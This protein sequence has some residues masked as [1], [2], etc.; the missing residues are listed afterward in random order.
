MG[1]P[2]ERESIQTQ[3]EKRTWGSTFA[4]HGGR[5]QTCRPPRRRMTGST[6]RRTTNA[7]N[8]MAMARITPISLGASGP[9]SAKVRKTAIMTAAAETTTRPDACIAPTM[10]CCGLASSS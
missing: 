5:Y 4:S 1:G 9:E 10:A 6:T 2:L 3:C 7:S 8:V